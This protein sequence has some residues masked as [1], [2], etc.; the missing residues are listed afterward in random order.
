MSVHVDSEVRIKIGS[1]AES[2]IDDTTGLRPLQC[3]Y[4]HCDQRTDTIS[5]S[6][7]FMLHYSLR[8]QILGRYT[9]AAVSLQCLQLHMYVY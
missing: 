9:G 1:I 3:L 8:G 2:D 4:T 5:V 6:I 7:S